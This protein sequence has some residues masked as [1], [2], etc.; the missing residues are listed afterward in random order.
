[1]FAVMLLNLVRREEVAVRLPL[2]PSHARR[3]RTC[4]AQ[5]PARPAPAQSGGYDFN[6]TQTQKQAFLF[7][8]YLCCFG[9]LGGAIAS[10][11]TYFVNPGHDQWVGAALVIQC[12]AI[13]AGGLL[14]WLTRSASLG[15]F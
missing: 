11:L 4:S 5:Q 10:L 1:M 6:G 14:Y 13:V 2:A 3:T 15:G 9:G 12:F 8:A 7:F